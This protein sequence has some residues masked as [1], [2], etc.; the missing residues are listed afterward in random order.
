MP[1][2][3]SYTFPLITGAL[4]IAIVLSC[5]YWFYRIT[6]SIRI[7]VILSIW[8]VTQSVLAYIGI[9]EITNTIPPRLV[10]FGVLPSILL[11][12]SMFVTK[13]GRAIVDSLDLKS[14]TYFHIIRIPVE[15][16]LFLLY[17]DKLVPVLMTFE[18]AN[19]DI[20]SGVSAPIIAYLAFK[21]GDV[22]KRLL[23]IWN[24]LSLLLLANV[25]ITAALSIPSPIQQFAFDQPNIAV[26]HFPFNLLP[27]VVVP[28]VLLCHLA[29]FRL[30]RK[31]P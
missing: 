6:K 28:L 10:L 26:L 17:K 22:R 12:V 25:V 8:A 15:I 1:K 16:V 27:A 2:D 19:F 31:L 11:I 24:V 13:N 23:M 5:I 18:G 20:L 9:F 14:L 4:F 3:L 7:L 29:S 30:L 21:S